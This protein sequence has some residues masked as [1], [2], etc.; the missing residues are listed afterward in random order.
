MND[1]D[2]L[3]ATLIT[4]VAVLVL[5]SVTACAY[6]DNQTRQVAIKS[7]AVTAICIK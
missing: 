5:T 2:K 6:F 7:G 4:G 3:V 1:F